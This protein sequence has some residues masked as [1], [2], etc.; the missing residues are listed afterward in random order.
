MQRVGVGKDTQNPTLE[1]NKNNKKKKKKKKA[2]QR[3][4]NER[5][6]G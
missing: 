6:E 2:Q 5:T 1:L 4:A 3:K